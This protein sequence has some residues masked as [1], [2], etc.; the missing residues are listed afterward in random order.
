MELLHITQET[1]TKLQTFE[2]VEQMNEAIKAYKNEYELTEADRNILDSISRYACKYKGV[3][4]LSKQKIAEEAGYT[5]RRTAIRAC[6]RMEALG[7]LKQYETRRIKGDKRRSTNVI[8]INNVLVTENQIED[9][10]PG[11]HNEVQ[12]V[13]ATS[14]GIEASSKANNSSNTYDTKPDKERIIHESIRNNTPAEIVDL[15]SPFFYGSELYKYVGIVFKAK[16]RPHAKVRIEAHLEAFRAC[17]FD[18]IRRFKAG[19]IRSLDAYLF[20]SIRALSRRLFV[21][22][23]T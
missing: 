10:S 21:E 5:S 17:I 18:V 19:Y 6:N 2:S 23:M 14:H 22:N 11:K 20:A 16:Y 8:V 3:C 7:I 12:H 4:Y 1:L 15:L 9:V 13:T